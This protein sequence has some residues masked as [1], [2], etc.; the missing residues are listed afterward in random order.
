LAFIAITVNINEA[1][2]VAVL[3]DGENDSSIP[4]LSI[5]ASVIIYF[6]DFK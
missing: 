6:H 1:R 2:T 3:S 5:G 4:K